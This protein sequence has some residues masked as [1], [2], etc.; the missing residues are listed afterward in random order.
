MTS[1][2]IALQNTVIL[3]GGEG[4]KGGGGREGR[5][6]GE[7]GEGEGE[8][9]GGRRE[10]GEGREEGG[11]RKGARR[12]GWEGEGEGEGGRGEERGGGEGRGG[13]VLGRGRRGEG[14]QGGEGGR[15]SGGEGGRGRGGRGGGE[16]GGRGREEGEEGGRKEGRGGGGM[17]RGRRGGT[18]VQLRDVLCCLH[19]VRGLCSQLS[20][21]RVSCVFLCVGRCGLSLCG[22]RRT[23][24]NP[25]GDIRSGLATNSFSKPPLGSA[26]RGP[27]TFLYPPVNSW[28]IHAQCSVVKLTPGLILHGLRPFGPRRPKMQSSSRKAL[29]RSVTSPFDYDFRR[30]HPFGESVQMWVNW[31]SRL[32]LNVIS[33]DLR[34]LPRLIIHPHASLEGSVHVPHQQHFN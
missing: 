32:G 25:K 17:G 16:E 5:G 22:R 6:G 33:S 18:G 13:E 28:M 7:K 3:T 4:G 31:D 29:I 24:P 10:R 34:W 27:E 20:C 21:V 19:R 8:G 23:P 9:G 30:L 1:M 14:R 12:R 2:T 11:K 15:V 26:R